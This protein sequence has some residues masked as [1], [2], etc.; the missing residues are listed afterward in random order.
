MNRRTRR[1]MIYSH[2]RLA[3]SLPLQDKLYKNKW[4]MLRGSNPRPSPCKGDA[5]PTELSIQCIFRVNALIIYHLYLYKSITFLK[6]FLFFSTF[7]FCPF[8]TKKSALST[9]LFI[10]DLIFFLL[11]LIDIRIV[12]TLLLKRQHMLVLRHLK[13]SLHHLIHMNLKHKYSLIV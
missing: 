3:T 11:V 6:F 1:E 12:K 2:L 13:L 7:L 4:W 8:F 5:L 10:Y 9:D